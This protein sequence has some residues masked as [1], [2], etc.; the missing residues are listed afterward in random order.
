VNVVA[1][2]FSAARLCQS[3]FTLAFDTIHL[4]L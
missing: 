3:S 4:W 1:K 2:K